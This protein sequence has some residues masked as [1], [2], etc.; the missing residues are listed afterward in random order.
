MPGSATPFQ[1][2]NA[3]GAA[4]SP[5]SHAKKE[6]SL[7]PA[8]LTLCWAEVLAAPGELWLAWHR[9]DSAPQHPQHPSP[10]QHPKRL[11]SQL[12]PTVHIS[13]RGNIPDGQGS[14][15]GRF[16]QC[17]H[18]TLLG[19]SLK[20]RPAAASCL[21]T[22]AFSHGEEGARTETAAKES[23]LLL[24]QHRW[25]PSQPPHPS[26]PDPTCSACALPGSRHTAP[27][28]KHTPGWLLCKRCSVM[29]GND[30]ANLRGVSAMLGSQP[31][32]LLLV[33]RLGWW[34][35]RR[36]HGAS[37]VYF[38][39]LLFSLLVSPVTILSAFD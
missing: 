24:P 38:G 30:R 7:Q 21:Y 11:L 9:G 25:L 16:L 20:A 34:M 5:T 12:E 26:R 13:P 10:G 6:T 28:R 17:C 37:Q 22:R 27:R 3:A 35:A 4:P 15:A 36:G 8:L 31:G 14:G 32:S 29:V 1:P 19:A 2:P 39:G 23:K 33:G 18:L